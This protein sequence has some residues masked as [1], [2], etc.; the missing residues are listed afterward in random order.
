[1]ARTRKGSKPPGFDYTARRPGNKHHSSC[2]TKKNIKRRTHK[3]ERKL[4]KAECVHDWQD[5][6]DALQLVCTKCG[7]RDDVEMAPANF[8]DGMC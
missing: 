1:M 2:P 8:G 5:D 6:G 7:A 4:S 3:A